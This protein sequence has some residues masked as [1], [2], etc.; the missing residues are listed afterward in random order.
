MTSRERIL[1][2][3]NHKEPDMIPLD[4]GGHDSSGISVIA[5][6]NLKKNLGFTHD[7]THMF[8]CYNQLAKVDGGIRKIIKPDTVMLMREPAKW[9]PAIITHSPACLVP[10]LWDPERQLDG[11]YNV[12]DNN[13]IVIARMPEGGYYFDSVYAPLAEVEDISGLNRF[14]SEI[15]TYDMPFYSDESI[16]KMTNRAK[17][18][19]EETDSAVVIN[20]GGHLLLAGQELFGYEKFMVDMM[21]NKKLVGAFFEMITDIY[22]KRYTQY[23]DKMK[24]YVNVMMICDDLGT[25]NGP[26]LSVDCYKQMIWPFQKKL[27]GFIKSYPG[28]HTLLHSCGS[29]DQFIPLFIE[30]GVDALNPVQVS[31][32]GMDTRKLKMNFGKD[33]TF[34]GGGCD[35]QYVLKNGTH[36]E[37]RDEVEKRISDLAPGGGF[38]FTQVHNIQP[39]VPAENII[40]M[41]DKFA[42]CRNY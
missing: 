12:M 38:I 35:T 15:E 11:S 16:D 2:T 42:T 3:I 14:A 26:V 39:D 37:I 5:Y 18:L 6:D 24:K 40:I 8:S 21:I 4:I 29:V 13:G 41:L 36:S 17:K 20:I 27:F 33:I 25:Q 9:K 10:E 22:I 28:I 34:W 1:R 19:Y 23:L 32:A 7:Q 30:A 31:A